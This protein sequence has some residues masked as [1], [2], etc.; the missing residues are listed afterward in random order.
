MNNL[1]DR[2]AERAEQAEVFE[3]DSESTSVGFE[4]NKLKSFE[5]NQTRGVAVRVV[6]EGRLGFAASSD[7]EA[8]DRLVENALES[9]RHGDAVPVQ[10]PGPGE[11]PRVSVYDEQLA[12]SHRL[13]D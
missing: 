5:V 7:M 8:L 6:N 13:A 3:I 1:L 12:T 4:A 11:G 10:F 9:A 2:L